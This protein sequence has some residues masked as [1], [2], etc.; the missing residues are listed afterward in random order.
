MSSGS[1]MG[2]CKMIVPA[3]AKIT[4]RIR[5]TTPVLIDAAVCQILRS[6]DLRATGVE[7]LFEIMAIFV[8]NVRGKCTFA[9]KRRAN[10]TLLKMNSLGGCPDA[11]LRVSL[12]QIAHRS[13]VQSAFHPSLAPSDIHHLEV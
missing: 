4:T 6:A 1:V 5:R 2:R 9:A 12:G 11:A 3:A 7:V 8:P 13:R 10:C